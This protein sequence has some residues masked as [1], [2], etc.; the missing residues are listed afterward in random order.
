MSEHAVV[1]EAPEAQGGSPKRQLVVEAAS[2]LFLAHGYGAVS[3]DAVA[4][5]AGVSKATLY[6][7]FPSKDALFGTLVREC[8]AANLLDEALF[9]A[10]VPDLRAALEAIGQRVL[11]FLLD[12]RRLASYRM[13]LAETERFPELGRALYANGPLRFRDRVRDWLVGLQARGQVRAGDMT[14][15]ASHFGGLLGADLLFRA[16]LMIPPPP[17]EAEIDRAVAEAVETWLRAFAAAGP[18]PDGG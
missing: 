18:A 3:M 9:P 13:A 2:D 15:A 14:V 12:P 8:A 1:L 16:R 17:G 4:R 10:V 7:H 5:R 11:R 6:A